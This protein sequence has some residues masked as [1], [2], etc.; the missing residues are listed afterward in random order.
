MIY[1]LRRWWFFKFGGGC[2]NLCHKIEPR[3]LRWAYSEQTCCLD[4]HRPFP[5]LGQKINLKFGTVW[6]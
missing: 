1:R 2:K 6:Q 4:C 3:L 5:P